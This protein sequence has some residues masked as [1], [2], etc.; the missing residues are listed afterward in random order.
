MRIEATELDVKDP[1]QLEKIKFFHYWFFNYVNNANQRFYKSLFHKKYTF[2]SLF[3]SVLN[4]LLKVARKQKTKH[5]FDILDALFKLK[6]L[7]ISDF[8]SEIPHLNGTFEL[9]AFSV[10]IIKKKRLQSSLLEDY[11]D[12][13]TYH[14]NWALID[15]LIDFVKVDLLNF[16]LTD[17][18]QY[19]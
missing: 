15:D 14:I 8:D 11:S 17:N 10:P 5:G 12:N 19:H 1:V 9:N 6:V 4:F 2:S 18:T 7:N 3:A 13:T 16:C